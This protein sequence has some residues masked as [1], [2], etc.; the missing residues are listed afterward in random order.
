MQCPRLDHFVKIRSPNPASKNEVVRVCCHMVNP[1][2]F[3]NYDTMHQSAWLQKT[4]DTFNEG[5]FPVECIRCQQVEELG[6][7]SIRQHAIEFHNTQTAPD[8]LVADVI[9]DN[10]CNSACQFCGPILST[11]IGSLYSA[12]Y[13]IVDNTP[14]LAELPLNR[15][16][17]LDLAG[18]E[19]SN[20][21]NIKNLLKN[22]PVNVN[23]IRLNT[24]CS[25][26]MNELIP[27]VKQGIRLSITVSTDGIN[28]VHEYVRWPIKWSTFLTTLLEYQAFAAA[29]PSLVDVNLWTT[30]NALNIGDLDNIIRFANDN[31]LPHSFNMLVFPPPLDIEF[32]NKLTL[33][34]KAKFAN[35]DNEV[36]NKLSKKIASKCDNQPQF[37]SFV[38]E[39]DALRK[40]SIEDYIK[41]I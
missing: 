16:V 31:S 36:L 37:D 9:L 26:F 2:D 3:I 6:L 32:S 17:Q 8:Y 35:S 20:S 30:V 29:Y 34:A 12:N 19:P 24:N 10:I 38:E 21:K 13:D 1:P 28:D 25:S 15:I 4:K 39:Q 5:I 27:L 14:H 33:L 11:K 18:G 41:I 7:T 22:L 40:I 23:S